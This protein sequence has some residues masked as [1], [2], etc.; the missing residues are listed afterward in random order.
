MMICFEC[1]SV[2]RMTIILLF[3]LVRTKQNIISCPL[4][5]WD[6]RG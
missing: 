5:A 1:R 3:D 2:H 4:I 6:M